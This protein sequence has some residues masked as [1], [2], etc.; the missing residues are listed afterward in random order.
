MSRVAVVGSVNLDAAVVVGHLPAP[1]ET[2]LGS[3]VAYRPGGKGGNQAVAARRLGADTV[4]FAAVGDDSAGTRL[5]AALDAEGLPPHGFTTVSGAATGVAM[6]LVGPDGEN[7]IVV[8]PGANHLLDGSR[9]ADLEPALGPGTVLALQL[10]I[11]LATCLDAAHRARAA[12]A[13]VVLNAAPLPKPGEPAFVDLL[14]CVDVLVV[15]ETEAVRL[16]V[17]DELPSDVDE[18]VVRAHRLRALG[19]R[20]VVVTL[21]ARGAVAADR[22]GGHV[23]D[24]LPVDTVDTTG[25]GDSFCGALAV[26]LAEGRPTGEA[27]RRGCAA[28]ALATTRMGAQSA[29]PTRTE[30]DQ[31]LAEA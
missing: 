23:Q 22:D 8:A 1:G 25:A 24:G 13:T 4:L 17:D 10:E 9:L 12:G 19:P 16:A 15:N 6:I 7:M 29:L 27:L 14:T 31:F 21:G 2:V 3:D 30:L 11:P 20:T 26:A 28:G 18:W 5:R